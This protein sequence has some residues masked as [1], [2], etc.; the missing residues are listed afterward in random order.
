[1]LEGKRDNSGSVLPFLMCYYDF[2]QFVPNMGLRLRFL[3][4]LEL[5]GEIGQGRRHVN[6]SGGL[7]K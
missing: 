3:F 7:E 1:M 6:S 2:D 4:F 5:L